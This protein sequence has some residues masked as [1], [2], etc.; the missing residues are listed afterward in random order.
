MRSSLWSSV[1]PTGSLDVDWSVW[2]EPWFALPLVQSSGPSSGTLSAGEDDTLTFA[3]TSNFTGHPGLV[4]YPSNF[5]D[6]TYQTLT[7]LLHRLHVGV[8]GFTV[9]PEAGY[10]GE[11]PGALPGDR[12][13]YTAFNGWIVEQDVEFEVSDPWIVVTDAYPPIGPTI[14]PNGS[15]AFT[16]ELDDTGL[17]T[18]IYDGTV[19]WRSLDS[20]N[21]AFEITRSVKL[22]VGRYISGGTYKPP[23]TFTINAANPVEDIPISWTGPTTPITDADVA[24]VLST[25]SLGSGFAKVSIV[26]PDLGTEVDLERSLGVAGG[27][28]AIFDDD[29]HPPEDPVHDLEDLNGEDPDGTWLLRVQRLSAQTNLSVALGRF[30]VRL[31]VD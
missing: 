1:P 14:L 18:G 3:V 21:P 11:G 26:S 30:E 31:H 15:N 6:T 9:A 24:V 23:L 28:D 13:Q 7:P 27:I 29:T 17:Q 12:T 10:A 22:D 5:S 25:L 16:V 8:D 4:D 19:T 2:L 20:G